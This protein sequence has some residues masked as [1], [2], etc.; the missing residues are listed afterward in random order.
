MIVRPAQILEKLSKRAPTFRGKVSA[1]LLVFL[2]LA[3]TSC[4]SLG[5]PETSE[6]VEKKI[7]GSG[8]DKVLLIEISG[9][10]KDEKK[11]SL[12]GFNDEPR[13]SARIKE[14][15]DK[16][17]GDSDVK[18]VILR[19]DTP[20]GWVTTTDIIYHELSEFKKKKGIPIVAQLMGTAASGG[21]YI[22]CVADKIVAHPTTVTGAI[23][24]V[25][26]RLN[27][28]GLMEKVGLSGVTIKSGDKKDMGSL[29]REPTEEELKI[30]GSI[31]D[32]MFERFKDVVL[33]K[34]TALRDTA[35]DTID[36]ALYAEV[37]D[38][39]VFGA[40]R[41]LEIGLIDEIGYM[42]DAVRVSKLLSG[43][44]EATIVTYARTGA[45]KSNIY[46][47]GFPPVRAEINLLKVNAGAM[48]FGGLGGGLG[49]ELGL[50]FMY[51]WTPL[52]AP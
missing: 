38:G 16:A 1:F 12:L 21:Y 37:F 20:G 4:I 48:T 42:E 9:Y 26:Y 6:L 22:A 40:A 13:L 51:L 36:E 31:I 39:R 44:E 8:P 15:L 43:I 29:L 33:D 5:L 7:G 17:A 14:E 24:V 34:R 28:S 25:A 41:A 27:A 11:R 46:S 52:G 10:I 23:G 50:G 32:G 49:G 18:A 3:L 19:I 47:G 35:T 45:Y 30:L 2:P